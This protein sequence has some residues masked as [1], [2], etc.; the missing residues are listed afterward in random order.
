[1][2]GKT[3]VAQ[4]QSP[5]RPTPSARFRRLA[6]PGLRDSLCV[7]ATRLRTRQPRLQRLAQGQRLQEEMQTS[8][9]P[10]HRHVLYDVRRHSTGYGTR[11]LHLLP[12]EAFFEVVHFI[13]HRSGEYAKIN[14]ASS[15]SEDEIST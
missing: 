2:V 4:G 11:D 5:R 10:F 9:T 3:R 7:H 1:M 13:E 14:R 15:F 6:R 8:R 12:L